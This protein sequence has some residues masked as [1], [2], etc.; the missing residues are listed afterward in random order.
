MEFSLNSEQ[1]LLED[2]VRKFAQREVA[3]LAAT[4]DREARFPV[5]NFKKMGEMGLLGI[6]VPQ[7]W[8][9]A[10][11]TYLDMMIATEELAAACTST[12]VAFAANATLFNDNVVHNGSE[13][14]KRKYLPGTSAGDLIGGIAMTEP[15]TGSDVVSM[16]TSARREGDYYVLNGTKILI[17][18]GPIGDVFIVYAKTDP[19]QGSNGISA[20][21][22][23]ATFPGF[24][25]GKTF[26]KL[27]W[28]GSPTGELVFED[29][30][31]P[32]E[33]LLGSLNRG[34]V[35]LMSGLNS[36]RVVMGA[37][38]V[39]LA[40]GAY[41]AALRY[42]QERHQFG[43]PLVAF[44][45]IQEKLVTI[46]MHLE[47]ARLL[48]YK[49]AVLMDG[50]HR[51]RQANLVASYAKLFASE[52]CMAATTEAVQILGGYGFTQDYPVERMMRDAK[53]HTIG[54]GTSEIQKMIIMRALL[55]GPQLD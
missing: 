2:N 44:Q 13:T 50:G 9:G 16:R 18:N 47:M 14:I 46:A 42:A 25:R 21:V 8:G 5:E 20:F 11:G 29:C 54:G 28:R 23:E 53:I 30:L 43:Q 34:I 27:G 38:S 36:E 3:P 55:E 12:A 22:V 48:V 40:R 49:G 24:R 52:M 10:G 37:L 19:L 15:D 45:L 32:A 17:T 26:A 51:G 39:G 7:A 41:E 1:K 33:N 6:T 31:V 4:I 35:V